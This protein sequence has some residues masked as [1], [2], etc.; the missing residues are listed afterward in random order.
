MELTPC[1]ANTQKVYPVPPG[2]LTQGSN[3]IV[4]SLFAYNDTQ[5]SFSFG[6]EIKF[7]VDPAVTTSSLDL[8]NANVDSPT[9]QQVMSGQ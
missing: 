4:L 5:A 7:Q 3:S 1:I 9:S 8:R 6:G 2:V